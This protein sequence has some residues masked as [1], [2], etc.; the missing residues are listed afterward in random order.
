MRQLKI[1][2]VGLNCKIQ[3]SFVVTQPQKSYINIFNKSKLTI[4]KRHISLPPSGDDTRNT[5]AYFSS[6]THR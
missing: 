4:G 1:L 5:S 3:D 2:N 6:S